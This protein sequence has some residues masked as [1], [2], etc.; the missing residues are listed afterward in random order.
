MWVTLEDG[1]VH[2]RTWVPLVGV[3]HHVLGRRD[4]FSDR[5]PLQPRRV[6]R[7]TAATQSAPR[8]LLDHLLRCHLR[9]YLGQGSIAAGGD[10]VVDAL[11]IDATAV[12]EHDLVLTGE[13][14]LPFGQR[15]AGL[16]ALQIGNEIV[17]RVRVDMP[18]Q[19]S[20]LA[21]L[22]ERPCRAQ[23]E[24]ANALHGDVGD[25]VA[26]KALREVREH[27]VG[28]GRQAA[29]GL[30]DGRR[31][32]GGT[33]QRRPRHTSAPTGGLLR[34]GGYRRLRLGHQ[35]SNRAMTWATVCLP[36]ASPS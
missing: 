1:T 5:R 32:A 9:D 35:S 18:E 31:D 36:L 11:R 34:R 17:R 6:T 25:T 19:L 23:P 33:R 4:L 22:N 27:P 7:A 21:H 30:A 15:I 24:A 14:R 16:G 3:A 29:G 20:G 28:L 8:H 26:D 2:E 13:E 12:L 10:V